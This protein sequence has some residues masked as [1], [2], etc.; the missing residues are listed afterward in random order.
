M[1]ASALVAVS[2]GAVIGFV[3]AYLL[4]RTKERH[5]LSTRW[6]H[7]LYAAGVSLVGAARRMTHLAG[8]LERAEDA[9]DLARRIDDE[10]QNLRVAVD[11]CRL[12]GVPAV[13][14]A[15]RRVLTQAY[16]MRIQAETGR[17]PHR[18]DYAPDMY[19]VPEQRLR[20]SLLAFFVATREQLHVAHATDVPSDPEPR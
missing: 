18:A 8:Q 12:L 9:P 1:Q 6:D 7:S 2:L 4:E 14:L 3:P 13:Q 17:D 10:H 20:A 5:E 11:Q 19:S 16:A 15:S